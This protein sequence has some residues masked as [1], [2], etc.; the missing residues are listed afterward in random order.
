VISS[1]KRWAIR[2]GLR[3]SE[4]IGAPTASIG[5]V[6]SCRLGPISAVASLLAAGVF[7]RHQGSN[8]AMMSDHRAFERYDRFR[9]AFSWGKQYLHPAILRMSTRQPLTVDQEV[10]GSS[11]PSC[12]R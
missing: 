3:W 12:T 10:G 5:D 6:R 1:K 4:P 9:L 2:S 8:A 11:P 7:N